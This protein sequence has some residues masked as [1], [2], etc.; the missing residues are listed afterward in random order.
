MIE[1]IKYGKVNESCC[2]MMLL[3]WTSVVFTMINYSM[4]ESKGTKSNETKILYY[5]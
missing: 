2:G 3:L 1:A 5:I 4:N